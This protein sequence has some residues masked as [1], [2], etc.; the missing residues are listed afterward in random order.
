MNMKN[1]INIFATAILFLILATSNTVASSDDKELQVVSNLDLKRFQGTWYEIAHNPWFVQKDCFAMIARYELV[2]EG[3]IRVK[4]ICRDN[5]F[6]GK[7]SRIEGKAWLAEKTNPAKWKVQFIW[8]FRLNYWIIEVDKDYQ[9]AVVGE[10]DKE[11]VWILSRQPHLDKNILD[12][13]IEHTR[14]QG[15]TAQPMSCKND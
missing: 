4:N 14:A 11:N 12:K 10:P 13:I 8:P 15:S 1:Y 7:V 5:G 2:E 9:Y 3:K 6:D